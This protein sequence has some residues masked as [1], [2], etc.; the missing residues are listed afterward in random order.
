MNG[1]ER[2]ANRLRQFLGPWGCQTRF[3]DYDELLDVAKLTFDVPGRNLVEVA[4][5][6]T[7]LGR[8]ERQARVKEAIRKHWPEPTVLWPKDAPVRRKLAA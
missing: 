4:V 8:V 7:K 6:V 1:L 3:L 2:Y 5:A